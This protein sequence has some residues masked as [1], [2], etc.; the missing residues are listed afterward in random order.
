M[1]VVLGATSMRVQL[2]SWESGFER[3]AEHLRSML[4]E[5]HGRNYFRS[6]APHTWTPRL[7]L[8]E[9]VQQYIVCVDLAGMVREEIDVRAED[10]VLHIEGVRRKPEFPSGLSTAS[11]CDEISVHAMEIDSGRFHRRVPIA[12]DVAVDKISAVYRNGYLWVS[13]PRASQMDSGNNS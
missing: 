5:M 8:Y 9:A 11:A 3:M 10:G 13:L 2:Q 4:E 6:H 7:N 1:M 12:E